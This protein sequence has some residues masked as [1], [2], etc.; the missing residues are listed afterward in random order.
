VLGPC[1]VRVKVLGRGGDSHAL[2]SRPA[3]LALSVH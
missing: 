3:D 1:D 2:A